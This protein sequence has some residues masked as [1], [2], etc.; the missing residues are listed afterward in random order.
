MTT[1]RQM[2]S[3]EIAGLEQ[4]VK[5]GTAEFDLVTYER[6]IRSFNE[7]MKSIQPEFVWHAGTGAESCI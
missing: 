7:Q 1:Q 6:L 3:G 5:S 4:A 2:T